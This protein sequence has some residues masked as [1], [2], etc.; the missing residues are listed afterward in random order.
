[1]AKKTSVKGKPIATSKKDILGRLLNKKVNWGEKTSSK[2]MLGVA[3]ATS[4]FSPI[5][6]KALSQKRPFNK[7]K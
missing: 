2:K 7:K 5:K 4:K 6:W 1:M 3:K